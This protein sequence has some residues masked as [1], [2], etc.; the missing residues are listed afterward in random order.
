LIVLKAELMSVGAARLDTMGGHPPM[1]RRF[2][3]LTAILNGRSDASIR[4]TDLC[5]TLERLGFAMRKRGSH[6]IF[7]HP[8]VPDR[9]TL[10][11]AGGQ[12]K[13]YQVRQVRRI[14]MKHGLTVLDGGSDDG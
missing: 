12:A 8:R 6:R 11:A 13:A 7:R 14:L 5:A 2:K 1:S 10:Q 3:I 4:F 9:I